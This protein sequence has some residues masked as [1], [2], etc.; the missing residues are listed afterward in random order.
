MSFRIVIVT[1]TMWVGVVPSS[2]VHAEEPAVERV[3]TVIPFPRGLA[4]K[5]NDDKLYVLARGRVRG[6]GGVTAEVN[7]RA[8]TLFAVNPNVGDLLDDESG[9]VARNNGEIFAEPDE[10]IF[11]LWDRA[12]SPPERDRYTDRPYCVLRYHEPSQSFYMCAF[13]GI[14]KPKQPGDVSFSKNLTDALLRYDLRTEQWYEVE[15]HNIEAGGNYPHH[16][17]Q[18]NEPPHGWLNGPDNCLPLGQWLYAVGKD[19]NRLV[20]YDLS[21][22]IDDPEAP[23]P[24]GYAVLTSE[25]FVQGQGMQYFYGHSA[26][27][28]DDGYLYVGTR[29]SSVIFRI[30]LDD[31]FAPVEPVQ[32]EV[33]AYFEPY[34]PVTKESADITDMGF[35]DKGRLYVVSAKPSRVYRFKPDPE[36]IYDD[37]KGHQ[38]SWV[39]LASMTNNPKMKSENLLYYNGYLY[40]TSGDGYAYQQGADG[41]VYRVAVSD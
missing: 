33:V 3:T 10:T 25:I 9:E 23:A 27:A 13:S 35:D 30:A 38:V 32:A 41:A 36:N 29:T 19:N 39:D 40:V 6:V 18:Y 16:D 14:D 28:Y 31:E 11:N 21:G 37:R 7:D 17:P 8:G 5:E 26:L 4:V 34:D 22:I 20:R 1:F 24:E 15:R 2:R 12:A